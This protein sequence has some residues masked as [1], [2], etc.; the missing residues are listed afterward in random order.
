MRSLILLTVL[1]MSGCSILV[2]VKAKFPGPPGADAQQPCPLLK[3]VTDEAKLSDVSKTVAINYGEY[4]HC[5]NKVDI[6]NEWYNT[7]KKIFEGVK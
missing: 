4:Y 3:P 1:F 7:Q 2:P 6:W 5:A